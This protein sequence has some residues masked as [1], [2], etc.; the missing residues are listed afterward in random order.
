MPL[1]PL[2]G[3]AVSH[4]GTMNP[5]YIP[6]SEL[7]DWRKLL[8]DPEKHWRENYSAMAIATAWHHASGFPKSVAKMF[9][10]AGQP[11]RSMEPLI[12]IPEHQVDLPGGRRPSQNDVWVL[13]RHS[14]GLASIAV[15]GKVSESFGETLTDWT[16]NASEGKR[17]RLEFLKLTLGLSRDLPE[18]IRYQLLHRMASA[19]IEAK[20][21]RADTAIMLVHSFSPDN[22]GLADFQAFAELFGAT[23][24]AGEVVRLSAGTSPAVWAGWARDA[25]SPP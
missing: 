12:I 1:H 23:C 5:V 9:E 22:V 21:F 18:T 11:F 7:G 2:I 13:A 10:A 24:N 8:A 17:E 20:R 15:E 25:H 19:I 4:F 3:S 16:K 6:A 14:A